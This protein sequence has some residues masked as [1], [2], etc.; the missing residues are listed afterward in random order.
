VIP[1]DMKAEPNKAI[2]YFSSKHPL[3]KLASLISYN[4][5]LRMYRTFIE[6]MKPKSTDKILDVGVT[7]DKNLPESNFFEALYPYTSMITATSIEDAKCLEQF[8]PGLHFVQTEKLSLPFADQSFD[9]VVSF[10][11]IEHVGQASEQ[12]L[13][14]RELLRVGKQIFLTTPNRFFP[15]EVHTFLPLIHWLPQALHQKILRLLNMH[16]WSKTE[17]LNLLDENSLK[18]L[19][20]P[21][22]NVTVFHNRT[23]GFSSNLLAVVNRQPGKV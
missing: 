10:A 17:N 9:I 19:F 21:E 6:L 16:F 8:Y 13:F 4:A 2:D 7:P 5:R 11:V 3:R 1:L 15:I 14:V 20:P 23:C 18:S 22:V 12:S